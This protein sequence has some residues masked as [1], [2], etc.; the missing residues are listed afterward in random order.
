MQL[1]SEDTKYVKQNETVFG[2]N[3]NRNIAK[4]IIKLSQDYLDYIGSPITVKYAINGII[5]DLIDLATIKI[6][7]SAEIVIETENYITASHLY[8][9]LGDAFDVV[10]DFFFYEEMIIPHG[11]YYPYYFDT[12]L[13]ENYFIDSISV[14]TA[15]DGYSNYSVYSSLDGRDFDF[16]FE[17]QNKYECNWET[18]DFYRVS[19]KEARIIRVYIEYNSASKEAL[20]D[21]IEFCGKKS[22]S[23]I[24]KRPPIEI[25]RFEDSEYNLP[26]TNEDTYKEV[27][28][29][30]ERMLGEKYK[31]WFSFCL[32][33][34]PK[35]NNYDYFKLSYKNEKI[36]IEGNNGIS[37]AVGLNHYLKYFCNVNI[38]QVSSNVKMPEIIP[39][40]K[41]VI[42][43]ET[44]AKVRYAYNYCTHSYSMAFFGEKEWEK[45]I[46]WLALNGVNVVLDITAQEEVWR[47]FLTSLGYS[48]EEI[49]K[50][51]AGPAYY[52]WSYMAN[53]SGFLGPVHDSW[54]YDRTNLARKN[55]LKMRRLGMSPV[56]QGYSGMVPNDVSNHI[57]DIEIIPQ[58]TWCSFDRPAMLRTTSSQFKIFADKFYLAQREVY[59]CVSNYFALDPFHEGGNTADM[60]ARE[61][62]K[63]LLSSML[64]YNPN[65][66]WIIQSWQTNP[67]SEL[68]KGINDVKNGKNHALIL[69]LYA[70]KSPNYN[71]GCKDNPYHGYSEEFDATPWVYCMLNNF[72]GRLGLH[73]HIDNL[74]SEIPNVFN[75][76]K[77]IKGIG[78]TPEASF[79][80]PVLYDF[81]FETVWTDDATIN[82]TQIDLKQWICAYC[83]RRYGEKNANCEKAWEILIDTVYKAEYNNLGQ[84]APESV[85]NAR[86]TLK[87]NSASSWGNSVISYP[88]EKLI[89]VYKLLLKDYDRLKGNDGYMYDLITVLQ[90]I[91]SNKALYIQEKMALAFK[92]GNLFDFEKKSNE[93]LYIA[94]LMDKVLSGSDYYRLSRWTNQAKALAE[95]ADD[96]SK[97]IYLLNSKALITTWGSYNQCET[98]GLHD[99]S[100]RQ[101]SGLISSFYKPRWELWI[102]ERIKELK[103]EPFNE[104]IN[105][106]EWEWNWVRESG[107]NYSDKISV[108]ENKQD[109]IFTQDEI[110]N[111][112][113]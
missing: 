110:L 69:D 88:K 16:L 68:L 7:E 103:G 22:G 78:I 32:A 11:A 102:N 104:H 18:G 31:A 45:E 101:W 4:I 92:S 77:Y 12:D 109:N 25:E 34:N 105:W 62:S 40:P 71:D 48:H 113:P 29:I 52:A 99:Y 43:K 24:Q 44:P 81:L 85:V 38:S 83:E 54:F 17:K 82:L 46:D 76:C 1:V 36:H 19:G 21:R 79:N 98:G 5:S 61:I 67:S 51:I 47:R 90:Q 26:V 64:R 74:A 39:V 100:N 63:C 87:I 70:E 14:F 37:L 53:L 57:A 27:Y 89:T 93:F 8:F 91:L 10:E 65:S 58:G 72:G 20:F 59:G 33:D 13:K 106:F 112:D 6:G 96:F 15:K 35:G 73:G 107:T 60:S 2:F 41:N 95:N 30:I 55:H 28:G 66:I 97:K 3:N 80:N 108:T 86:P 94:D 9:F 75:K 49:L 42:F 56:L 50:F 111:I 84:G 23:K